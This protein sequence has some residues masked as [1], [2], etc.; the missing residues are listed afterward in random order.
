[1]ITATNSVR[2]P[3][4]MYR[5]S[6][7]ISVIAVKLNNGSFNAEADLTVSEAKALR[8]ELNDLIDWITEGKGEE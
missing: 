2:D 1:M 7:D 4:F 3:I 6:P 8:D 5:M